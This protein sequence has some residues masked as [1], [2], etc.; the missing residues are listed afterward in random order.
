MR[1]SSVGAKKGDAGCHKTVCV[2]VCVR[3][4][5]CAAAGAARRTACANH[6]WAPKKAARAGL[7]QCVFCARARQQQR[8][9]ACGVCY[10]CKSGRQ[11]GP[12]Q[13]GRNF[14]WFETVCVRARAAAA[15]PQGSAPPKSEL[16]VGGWKSVCACTQKKGGSA[17][18]GRTRRVL[19]THTVCVVC[20]RAR[21]TPPPA[22]YPGKKTP[23]RCLV[24]H[25]VGLNVARKLVPRHVDKR[26]APFAPLHVQVGGGGFVAHAHDQRVCLPRDEQ[27]RSRR[28]AVLHAVKAIG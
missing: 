10:R 3:A 15:A 1:L 23:R 5:A 11:K 19:P 2:C 26:A 12:R 27:N 25:V 9:E 6:V 21:A 7:K 8:G 28:R 17:V 20:A 13:A 4:R 18:V 22:H 24:S 14:L 16:R